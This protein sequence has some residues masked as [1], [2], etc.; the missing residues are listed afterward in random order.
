MAERLVAMKKAIFAIVLTSVLTG[1]GASV[2][3][4]PQKKERVENQEGPV[5]GSLEEHVL[6]LSDGRVVTCV[7]L[8][9]YPESMQC[10]FGG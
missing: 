6:T 3:E 4:R 1:C 2:E 10:D 8:N 7:V 9:N 5:T